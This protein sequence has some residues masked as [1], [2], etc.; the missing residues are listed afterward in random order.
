MIKKRLASFKKGF[1]LTEII[2]WVTVVGIISGMV[3]VGGYSIIENSKVKRCKTDLNSF[4]AALM[5][6]HEARGAF[7]TEDEGLDLLVKS[8]L[9]E[10]GNLQDPW[11]NPYVYKLNSDE[12]GYVITSYGSD[13]K[14]GGTGNAKDI[15]IEETTNHEL[16]EE[17][18]SE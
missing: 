3:L 14:E 6:Y 4:K 7:P 11:K 10:K 1:S 15:S 17:Q 9:L 12:M 18:D 5:S 8:G 16:L 2:I 13:K